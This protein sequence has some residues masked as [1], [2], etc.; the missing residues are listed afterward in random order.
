MCVSK[1]NSSRRIRSL[2]YPA[3]LVIHYSIR[4]GLTQILHH[5]NGMYAKNETFQNV[6]VGP[7]LSIHAF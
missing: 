2:R 3:G 4:L 7:N 5:R 6:Y 1:N